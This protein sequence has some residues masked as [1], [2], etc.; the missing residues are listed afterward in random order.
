M[1][2]NKKENQK[3]MMR[4]VCLVLAGVFVLSLLGTL[5]LQIIAA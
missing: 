4:L 5:V 3:N 2:R 1:K